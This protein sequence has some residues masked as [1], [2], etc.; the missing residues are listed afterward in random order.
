MKCPECLFENANEALTCVA[1]GHKFLTQ[2]ATTGTYSDYLRQ[3]FGFRK[4]ITPSLIRWSYLF[5]ALAITMMSA[6]AIVF[7]HTF[8]EYGD[9][10]DRVVFGGILLL[11]AG[12]VVWRMMCE[13]AIL[14][15]SLHE[16]L[17]SLDDKAK[18]LVAAIGSQ[19]T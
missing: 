16:I 11:F 3:Y 2:E 14:V 19:H 4:L 12:N 13:G 18:S 1:C 6:I 8:T 7:P 17:V 9:N 15:F 10:S 5:G